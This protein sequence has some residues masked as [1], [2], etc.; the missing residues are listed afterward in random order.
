M[1]YCRVRL[2]RRARHAYVHEQ[3]ALLRPEIDRDQLLLDYTATR[4]AATLRPPA[5]TSGR[6]R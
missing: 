3:T 5:K 6:G 4:M 2:N 1:A